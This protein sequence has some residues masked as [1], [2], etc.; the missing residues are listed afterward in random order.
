M[1]TKTKTSV[2]KSLPASRRR[3][4]LWAVVMILAILAVGYQIVRANSDGGLS[5]TTPPGSL[6]REAELDNLELQDEAATEDSYAAQ[7]AGNAHGDT[8]GLDRMTEVTDE[9]AR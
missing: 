6:Q 9:A 8:T 2:K 5:L 7:Q 4:G 3:L 1:K